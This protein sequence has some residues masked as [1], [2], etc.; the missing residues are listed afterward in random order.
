[1]RVGRYYF[2]NPDARK[3]A[4]DF[5]ARLDALGKEGQHERV[6]DVVRTYGKES[7]AVWHSMQSAI[8]RDIA[9]ARR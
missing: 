2:S 9:D 5:Y 8:P 6:M 7:G 4:L 3:L 1:M